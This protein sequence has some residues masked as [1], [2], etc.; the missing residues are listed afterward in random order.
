MSN[1]FDRRSFLLYGSATL[2]T[3]LLLKACASSAPTS[4]ASSSPSTAGTPAQGQQLRMAIVLPGVITDGGWNQLGY[5]GVKRAADKLGAEVA[6]VEKVA[7]A[8]QTESLS[9]FARQGYNVVVG[10]GGQFDAAIEQVAGEFPDSFFLA[11]N[12]TVSGANYAAVQTN[13]NQVCYLAGIVGATMSKTKKLAYMAGLE[14]KATQQQGK[15]LELAAKSVDPKAEVVVNYVG[16]FN[17]IAKA[18]ESAL[19]LISSGVDVIV[20]NLDNSAPA[21]LETAQEKGIYAIGN[22]VDQYDLAPKAVLTSMVQDI[23]GAITYVAELAGQ[24]KAEG[25]QY[26]IGLEQP[27]LVRMGKFNEALPADLKTKVANLEKRMKDG[28]LTFEDIEEGGKASVRLV[29][30]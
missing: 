17:D 8:D 23:G 12:G 15:V 20:H 2:A 19:A 13:Y 29:E 24:G 26:V 4:D 18:K 28:K 25:K 5:E 1:K 27:D 6:Y 10:H 11:V 14:F 9:E 16:D 7:Q 3:S 21:V 30:S 22:A